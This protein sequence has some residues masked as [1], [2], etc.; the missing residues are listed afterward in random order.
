MTTE[1]IKEID[2]IIGLLETKFNP[3]H[4]PDTGRFAEGSGANN[5]LINHF[6]SQY[7]K[8]DWHEFGLSIDKD[9]NKISDYEGSTN[10]IA[11]TP[12]E[13]ANIK[14]ASIFIHNH[15][16]GGSFSDGD[17]KFASDE[18]IGQMIVTSKNYDYTVAPQA[19]ENWPDGKE[20]N[21]AW[22]AE[23]ERTAPEYST[24]YENAFSSSSSIDEG[25]IKLNGI[26]EDHTNE[27]MQHLATKFN[28]VYTRSA[29]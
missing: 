12:E 14:D 6:K 3:N 23:Y 4:D 26:V 8:E 18:N 27:I 5:E 13:Q 25:N 9:G 11:M 19:G 20:M 29:R 15:P 21:T 24:R 17:L 1:I 22:Y 16:S 2:S 7:S 10:Q 28:L